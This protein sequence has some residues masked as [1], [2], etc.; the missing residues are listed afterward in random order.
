M[1]AGNTK[2][3]RP[4]RVAAPEF[5]QIFGILPNIGAKLQWNSI[6]RTIF[7]G[8]QAGGEAGGQAKVIRSG[9]GPE[10]HRPHIG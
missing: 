3:C 9:L 10:W 8:G 6:L 2:E 5:K 1:N 7:G 4:R